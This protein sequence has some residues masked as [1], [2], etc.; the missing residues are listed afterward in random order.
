MAKKDP[1]LYERELDR[2]RETLKLDYDVALG[3]Y[4]LTL[5][6][7]VNPAESATILRDLG[8]E[9]TEAVDFYNLGVQ[10]AQEE[11]WSEAIVHFKRA[12]EIDE[13]MVQAIHNLALCYE[14]TG[15]VPQ[16]KSTWEVYLKHVD[17]DDQ[18]RIQEH[19]AELN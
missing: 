9:L 2:Y 5:L 11:N 3:R 16:A 4:G 19:M 14:K 17:G 7:S 13:E 18:E 8:F 1:D 15:H 6:N 12:V 10:A